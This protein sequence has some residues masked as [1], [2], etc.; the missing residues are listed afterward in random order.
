MPADKEIE[1]F[2]NDYGDAVLRMCFLYLKDYHLAEDAAQETF[3][4]AMNSYDFFQHKSSEKTWLTKIAINV[5]KNMMRTNWFQLSRNELK[6][7]FQ[8]SGDAI[9]L[10]LEQDSLSSAIM[11]LS[12]TDRKLIWN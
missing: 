10:M 1:R 7:T 8:N 5:C 2:M 6:D 3:I 11:K 4:K 12:M 9:E